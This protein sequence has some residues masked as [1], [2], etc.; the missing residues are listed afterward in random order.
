M[1]DVSPYNI[2]SIDE[3]NTFFFENKYT[4]T[5]IDYKRWE[6]CLNKNI[7]EN[8]KNLKKIGK[9]INNWK[10]E[11]EN[12]ITAKEL[13]NYSMTLYDA[14]LK[15]TFSKIFFFIVLAIVYIYFFNVNGIIEPIKKLFNLVKTKITVDIPLAAD[16]ALQK[17][18]NVSEKVKNITNVT[19]KI[20][21]IPKTP[22]I[23]TS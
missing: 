8:V 1:C 6:K 2:N 4:G 9:Q 15:Y 20:K 17:I 13:N 12:D 19:E 11:N 16:K 22:E 18:P 14:D 10:S 23:K 3:Y 7:K 5:P 21:N